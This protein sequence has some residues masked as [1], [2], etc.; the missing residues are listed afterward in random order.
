MNSWNWLRWHSLLDIF[1]NKI[2]S[3]RGFVK[4]ICSFVL[5]LEVGLG[6]VTS[7]TCEKYYILNL[8]KEIKICWP[9]FSRIGSRFTDLEVKMYAQLGAIST[10]RK[11]GTIDFFQCLNCNH[12]NIFCSVHVHVSL[13]E[14]VI[15]CGKFFFKESSGQA[16]FNPLKRWYLEALKW[17]S[18]LVRCGILPCEQTIFL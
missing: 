8:K 5:G 14:N 15:F 4:C 16:L 12:K 6:K 10:W 17:K 1:D 2:I 9:N 7:N 3:C 18:R 11:K 13:C